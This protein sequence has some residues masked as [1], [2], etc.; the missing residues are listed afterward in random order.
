MAHPTWFRFQIT[1][2]SV[3]EPMVDWYNADTLETAFHQFAA[4]S[5]H[6]GI[7]LDSC[8]ITVRP[9]AADEAKLLG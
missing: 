3:R 1:A 7:P 5:R 4:D 6:Y 9:A 2:P 8:T